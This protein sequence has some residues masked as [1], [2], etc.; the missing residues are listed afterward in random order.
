LDFG[1]ENGEGRAVV[2][3][4][5]HRP[6]RKDAATTKNGRRKALQDRD[7]KVA[8]TALA[9]GGPVLPSTADDRPSTIDIQRPLH[10]WIT[11]HRAAM[12]M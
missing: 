1:F 10:H 11:D 4:G 5:S 7:L 9:V 6:G 8:P 3:A 12:R 2:A